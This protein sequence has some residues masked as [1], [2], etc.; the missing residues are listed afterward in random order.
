MLVSPIASAA[1]AATQP[2]LT[3]GSGALEFTRVGRRT[4]LTRALA[5]SPLKVLNPGHAGASA[6]AYLATY[7]GG[8]VGGDALDVQVTV[9]RGATA[10]LA[11]QASTKVYR[12]PVGAQ[13]TLRAEV[14]DGGLLMVL[15]DP[16][17]CFAG[18]SYRQQQRIRLEAGANLV[19]VDRLTAGRVESGERWLF[20]EYVARTLIWRADSL[21]LHEALQLTRDD[22]DLARRL[23]RFNALAFIVLLGPA[24]AGTAAHLARIVE[25]AA[26]ER[27][28]DCLLSAAQLGEDG[29]I[30]RV[31][32]PSVEQ[33]SAMV[34]QRLHGVTS[35]LGDDPWIGK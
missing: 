26:V 3:A 10:L 30:L 28:A 12:S 29:A 15:P 21:L 27:R 16:V 14:A 13:H 24:L 8:L 5:V 11:T 20:D 17:T 4:V 34:R 22:G 35:L 19:L 23:D 25:S 7:G 18:S 33:L 9:R 2:E 32:S 1:A 6:W 31:A